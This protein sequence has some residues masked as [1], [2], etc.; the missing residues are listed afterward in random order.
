VPKFDLLH[1]R[2]T[3]CEEIADL[4]ADFADGQFVSV[5][6]EGIPERSGKDPNV[7][8]WEG[9]IDCGGQWVKIKIALPST[10]PDNPP[11]VYLCDSLTEIPHVAADRDHFVCSIN[12]DEVFL[13]TKNP[14]LIVLDTLNAASKV[15]SDGL[16]GCNQNDFDLEFQAYWRQGIGTFWLSLISPGGEA[17]EVSF[18]HFRPAI[19]SYSYLLA[20]TEEDAK[21][22]LSNCGRKVIKD[23]DIALYLPLK[24]SL[25]PPFPVVNR[26]VYLALRTIDETKLESLCN[27]LTKYQ[28]RSNYVI[29]SFE[30]IGYHTFGGWVHTRPVSSGRRPICP[31]F[32]N[33]HIPGEQQLSSC[34]GNKNIIRAKV[35]RVD[36]DRLQARVGNDDLSSISTKH[37]LIVGCGSIGGKIALLLAMSGINKLTLVDKETLSFENMARHIAPMSAVGLNKANAVAQCINAKTPN[38]KIQKVARDFYGI[39]ADS[40]SLLEDVDLVLS[41]TADRNLN[42]RINELQVSTGK[43]FASLYVW[44]EAFGYASHAILVSAGGGGCLNCTF[45]IDDFE[46]RHRVVTLLASDVSRQEA[47]CGSTFQPYSTIDADMAACTAIRLALS[48]FH[49]ETKQSARWVYLGNLESARARNIPISS[50]YQ[51]SG[52]N[53]LIKNNLA[54]QFDCP[55]CQ[56]ELA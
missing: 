2:K 3:A 27:Y 6:E 33:N 18:L 15:I 20:E 11:I 28:K 39:L 41:A 31:G 7:V 32:R 21:T 49:G 50:E 52:S 35:E 54:S 1:I 4:F 42:H 40:F 22:W 43:A 45:E 48:Y 9:A 34:R 13:N 56:K 12:R 51:T 10:F 47:G 55:I 8:A 46:Y 14:K 16:S 5:P 17:R 44:T 24:Q 25:R 29:F 23:L 36:T 19:D 53:K 26:E 38:T 30:V 37:V